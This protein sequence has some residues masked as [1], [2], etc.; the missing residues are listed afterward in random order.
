[1]YTETELKKMN[2]PDLLKIAADSEISATDEQT[3]SEIVKLILDNGVTKPDDENKPD[4]TPVDNAP[5]FTKAQ[6]Q[7]MHWYSHKR[8][9]LNKVLE[10]DKAYSLAYVEKL[11]KK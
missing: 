8:A 5:K 1:M 10:D 3:K 4:K 9:E 6:I 2:K 7:S 11:L